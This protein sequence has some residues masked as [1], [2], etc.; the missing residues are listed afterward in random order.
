MMIQLEAVYEFVTSTIMFP[1]L[2]LFTFFSDTFA[3]VFVVFFVYLT[4]FAHNTTTPIHHLATWY[5]DANIS[6]SL[7][8]KK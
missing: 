1:K 2:T 7:V 8:I 4:Q 3:H 6:I 5:L